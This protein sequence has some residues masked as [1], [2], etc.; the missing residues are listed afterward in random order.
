MIQSNIGALFSILSYL[1]MIVYGGILLKKMIFREEKTI[2]NGAL[3]INLEQEGLIEMSRLQ[4]T[5]IFALGLKNSKYEF[6]IADNPYISVLLGHAETDWKLSK[7]ND[8]FAR[9]CTTEE[10]FAINGAW[11]EVFKGNMICLDQPSK[12]KIQSNWREE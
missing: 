3:S 9:K 4:D 10:A 2:S 11:S 5:F 7:N 1:T 12:L 8:T 6:D